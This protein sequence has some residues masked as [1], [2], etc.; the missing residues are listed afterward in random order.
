MR[1]TL[2]ALA[3]LCSFSG[4]SYAQSGNVQVVNLVC[5]NDAF[6]AGPPQATNFD[7]GST[8]APNAY[9]DRLVFYLVKIRSGSTFTF[10]VQSDDR[11]DYDFLSWQ[12]PPLP[13]IGNISVDDINNLPLADR[14]NRNAGGNEGR[15]GLRLNAPTLCQ[16]VSGDGFERHYDVQPGDV[17]L[18]GIDRW[19]S[20]GGFSISFGGD[21]DLDCSITVPG[22]HFNACD[23]GDGTATW[24]LEPIALSLM[25]DDPALYYRIFTDQEE[26]E[27]GVGTPLTSTIFTAHKDNNPNPLYFRI[28][29]FI[30]GEAT[31]TRMNFNVVDPPSFEDFAI[32]FCDTEAA[33][34]GSEPINLVNIFTS[35]V[36]DREGYEAEYYTTREDAEAQTNAIA[37]PAAYVVSNNTKAYIRIAN[38]Y[39]CYTIV[40]VTFNN[41]TDSVNNATL[42]YCDSLEDGLGVETVNLRNAESEILGDLTNVTVRYYP[43]REDA[44][45]GTNAIENPSSYLTPF[46]TKVYAT[47]SNLG[48][49]TT[50]AEIDIRMKDMEGVANATLEICDSFTDGLGVETV[51]LTLAAGQLTG[52]LTG[53]TV[54]YYPTEADALANTNEIT[55]PTAY[56]LTIGNSV[57]ARV[58]SEDGCSTVAEI[59]FTLRELTGVTEPVITYCDTLTDGFGTEVLDLTTVEAGILQA[60]PG[61]TFIYYASQADAEGNVNPIDTPTA[62]TYT[63]GSSV[64]VRVVDPQGCSSIVAIRFEQNELTGAQDATITFCDTPGDGEGVEVLD[65]TIAQN[66]LAGSVAGATF[67]YYPTAADAE[68]NTNAID[69]PSAY[70]VTVGGQVYVRVMDANGCSSI[71]MID[72]ALTELE[73]SLGD[74]FA[75]CDGSVPIRATTNIQGEALTYKWF[76]NGQEIEGNFGDTYTVTIPG[77]YGVEVVSASGCRGSQ[78][79]VIVEGVGA[80]ITGIEVNERNVTVNA[81][82]DAMPLQY[83]LD[84]INWQDSNTFTNVE[85]GQHVVYVKNAEGCISTREFSI[86]SIPTMFTPNG[87]GI[88]DTWRVQGIELYQGSQLEIYDRGGRLLINKRIESNVLWDGFYA[89]GKKAPSTDYWYVIKLTDGRKFTGSVTVKSRGPKDNN[90]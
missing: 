57:Y 22:E 12:N 2:I 39:D 27:S 54:M 66:Q 18:I 46:N 68:N 90:S 65:L 21:A 56:N 83:S 8:C 38:E 49:C 74:T 63:T 47:V 58:I 20:T 29:N 11:G 87:D 25:E 69:N 78:Q 76:F 30:T 7:V 80:T 51:D 73:V 26:A 86:F 67:I 48:G 53:A 60:Y 24:D 42:E 52:D 17:I 70:M 15:I 45:N 16:G 43:T 82:S 6:E 4:V 28:E 61:V 9:S 55:T 1:K 85:G 37:T 59:T 41:S 31:I 34:Q 62:Y 14:G 19:S 81:T 35:L 36:N 40:E 84:G 89:D 3:S 75:I 13:D 64:Y 5:S 71:Q 33:G 88:N 10:E 44:V 32:S 72:F 79:I 23:T 50:I 77:T